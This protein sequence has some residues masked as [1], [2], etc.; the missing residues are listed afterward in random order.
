M[1][2]LAYGCCSS[3]QLPIVAVMFFAVVAALSLAVWWGK[4]S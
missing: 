3:S 1:M 2:A 4:R